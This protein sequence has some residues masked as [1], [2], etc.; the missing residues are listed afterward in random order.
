MMT[1]QTDNDELNTSVETV[2]SLLG[3]RCFQ[4]AAIQR[5]FNWEAPDCAALFEDIFRIYAD[6]H[7]IEPP[8]T[9]AESVETDEA[10]TEFDAE[11]DSTDIAVGL[12]MEADELTPNAP[13][14]YL[15]GPIYL[16]VKKE[17]ERQ[18][19]FDGL[20]RITSLTLLVSVLRD[21]LAEH[22]PAWS[23]WLHFFVEEGEAGFRL[24]YPSTSHRETGT[25][26]WLEEFGQRRGET[27]KTRY[28]ADSRN[29]RGRVSR[30]IREFRRLTED[31]SQQ[32]IAGFAQFLLNNVKL[33]VVE[34]GDQRIASQAFVT[35]NLRG[36]PLTSVDILKGRMMDIAGSI[37]SARSVKE[38]WDRIRQTPDLEGFMTAV[39]FIERRKQ[40]GP[41]HLMELGDY[42]AVARPGFALVEWVERLEKLSQSWKILKTALV[43]PQQDP[44][45]GDLWRLSL[46]NW[47]EW[48]PLALYLVHVHELARE[49]GAS[50][51]KSTVRKRF[52]LFHRRAI[53][54][55]LAGLGANARTTIIARAIEQSEGL[56]GHGRVIN[57][58]S[59]KGGA[60]Q[61][62][63]SQR[64]RAEVQLEKGFEDR[65]AR[66]AFIQW[67]ESLQWPSE[68]LPSYIQQGTVEHILPQT[69]ASE[70]QQ[71][72]TDFP[73]FNERLGLTNML[74]NL[75]LIDR[76]VNAQ[77]G[78]LDF[79]D[80]VE[81][82]RRMN[83][84][85]AMAREVAT[86]EAWTKELILERTEK[87]KSL[88][89]RELQ[90][91]EA[92]KTGSKKEPAEVE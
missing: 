31:L 15:L 49:L 86:E 6:H 12:A 44:F 34:I 54:I 24:A 23:D 10:P 20:Q 35:S 50:R 41:A 56:V 85:F 32:H 73:D 30:A 90:W 63:P 71:W 83:P 8:A 42:L 14:S 17:G 36:V 25:A 38:S 37:D 33:I 55:T 74:G 53:G 91:D 27:L 82:Y 40:Q 87:M 4:P 21:R 3:T 80:K 81:L 76:A 66:A 26:R 59:G 78:S 5:D 7:V 1:M 13:N 67:L 57:C 28:R 43:D 2:A 88:T 61:L 9:D 18:E 29:P 69:P 48:R 39:D 45:G 72:Y 64:E 62:K 68:H 92:P 19:I 89:R 70:D 75:I 77:A 51:R 22:N 52:E 58:M 84:P 60:L 16:G 11:E 65:T 47:S 46:M 79:A